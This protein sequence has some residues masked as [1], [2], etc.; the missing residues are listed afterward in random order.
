MYMAQ[1][2]IH[3][4]PRFEKALRTLM[5][6]RGLKTKSEAVRLAVEEAVER[7]ACDVA[8]CD[9]RE[10]VGRGK[11]TAE[12]PKPRFDGHDQLWNS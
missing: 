6:R 2:N 7:T 12:N 1:L 3:L 8:V 9:F 11:Q 4:T 10:W 5:R